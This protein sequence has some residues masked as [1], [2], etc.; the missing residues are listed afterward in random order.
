MEFSNLGKHC[1]YASCKQLDFLPFTCNN[2]KQVTCLEHRSVRKHEC[3]KLMQAS[4]VT[5]LL[6]GLILPV[7]LETSV[8]IVMD[9]HIFDGC[10]KPQSVKPFK[11]GHKGCKVK[12]SQTIHCKYCDRNFCLGH[13]FPDDHKCGKSKEMKIKAPSIGPFRI[14]HQISS[15][16]TSSNS[17]NL[18]KSP[19]DCEFF[20]A[21]RNEF[22]NR[23]VEVK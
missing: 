22:A 11:C 17:E 18:S 19:H 23:R 1:A 3:K 15:S 6:C 20:N 8:D 13:R 9:Q 7:P 12:S 16:S 4:T 21:Q 10:K 5:C 14:P 2:C